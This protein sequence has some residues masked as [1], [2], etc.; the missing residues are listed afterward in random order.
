VSSETERPPR[1]R[2]PN[3]YGAGTC[4]AV[5]CLSFLFRNLADEYAA[6]SPEFDVHEF[7]RREALEV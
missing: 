3:R 4:G 6:A 1:C 2:R 5:L 7:L